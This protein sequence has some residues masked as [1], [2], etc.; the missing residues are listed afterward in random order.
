MVTAD[1][2][3]YLTVDITGARDSAFVRERIFNKVRIVLFVLLSPHLTPHL[4]LCVW[5]EEHQSKFSIYQTEI[6]AFA[7]GEALT[8]DRLFEL[9]RERG[10]SK[11]SLKFLVSHSSAVVHEHLPTSSNSVSPT[12]TTIPPPVLPAPVHVYDSY[13][14]LKPK[15]PSG[16]RPASLSSASEQHLG[17]E[18]S[19][20]YD[21]S[22]SDDL[23]RE[24]RDKAISRPPVPPKLGNVPPSPLTNRR[25]NGSVPRPVSPIGAPILPSSPPA[26]DR[27]RTQTHDTGRHG[28][29]PPAS[30]SPSRPNFTILDDNA[31]TP[32]NRV[33]HHRVGSDPAAE[34]EQ[35][36]R[37]SDDRVDYPQDQRKRQFQGRFKAD[38]PRDGQVSS[39]REK[40][41]QPD[42]ED[43]FADGANGRGDSWVVVSRDSVPRASRG[44]Q[45]SPQDGPRPSTSNRKRLHPSPGYKVPFHVRGLV[46]PNPPRAPP[47]VPPVNTNDA[48]N[49]PPRQVGQPVPSNW[50]VTW[51]GEP[52][53]SQRP[54]PAAMPLSR[55]TK[56][57]DK[58]KSMDNLRASAMANHPAALQPGMR[59]AALPMS[60]TNGGSS[61]SLYPPSVDSAS[62]GLPKSFD[63]QRTL[64]RPP[65][66]Q[67]LDLTYSNPGLTSPNRELIPRPSSALGDSAGASPSSHRPNRDLRSPTRDGESCRS[68][69]ALSPANFFNQA[70]Q[71]FGSRLHGNPELFP[72][73]DQPNGTDTSRTP[74][75]SP[76]SPREPLD[77]R[78][79]QSNQSDL[80]SSST[81]GKNSHHVAFNID[82]GASSASGESTLMQG[83]HSW[84]GRILDGDEHADG[85][86]LPKATIRPG[87]LDC[88][89]EPSP[90]PVSWSQLVR[91]PSKRR[92][93]LKEDSDSDD[94]GTS[95]WQVE[96]ATMLATLPRSQHRGPP[97][98]VQIEH[99]TY[100]IS[101]PTTANPISSSSVTASPSSTS[102]PL[103]AVPS[104]A[105]SRDGETGAGVR[106][107]TFKDV[108]WA[109]RPPPEDVY[110]RLE[111]FF[112][113]HDLDKPVIEAFSGGTSPTAAD[114]TIVPATP[115]NDK[116]RV[117]GKKSIRIVAEEHKK[118][119]DRT[120]R[121]DASF[122]SVLR[123]RSTKLWGSRLEEVTTA[124]PKS[125]LSTSLP[126]S[127]SGGPKRKT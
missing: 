41:H 70:A 27:L 45:S 49:S 15:R 103:D 68:P 116:S 28:P 17:P 108:S 109:P 52:K 72:N 57:I 75:R 100:P 101:V 37:A 98:K 95:I 66:S 6:G 121:A 64:M 59:R 36:L 118:R 51:K 13:G 69:R 78:D 2:E 47:P 97:L 126:D 22:V 106:A 53:A 79:R 1:S 80:S 34:R 112:P 43:N 122:T 83:D 48:R 77:I 23:D 35:A 60:R 102:R 104:S 14:P 29:L 82:I 117:K 39:D 18:P 38:R 20:G 30:L 56:P 61:V 90:P 115:A 111:E 62:R 67:S 19:A 87:R 71:F 9:C 120:S 113:G 31:P 125:G 5:D 44:Q 94:V 92:S 89:T 26:V 32:P 7:I 99:N 93:L 21:A 10:D 124:Q 88:A 123:K 24:E 50:A 85:T 3:R 46:I 76:A 114:Y 74:P 54:V 8:G 42:V 55:I 40:R 110:D 105:V 91:R 4:Q 11:G 119:I 81:V 63:T 65:P 73:T 127:P 25:P 84:I 33:P 86:L 96:P 58:S 16:S 107:S 12:V